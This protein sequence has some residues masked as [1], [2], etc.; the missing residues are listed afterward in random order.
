MF[1][2]AKDNFQTTKQTTF[3]KNAYFFFKNE[4]LRLDNVTKE[5]RGLYKC[6]ADNQVRPPDT[7]LVAVNVFFK[8]ETKPVQDTVGQAQNR[9]FDAKLECRVSG[10]ASL[11]WLFLKKTSRS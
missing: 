7:Y 6:V 4:I 10:N 3:F 2:V 9:Q 8:P 1:K 5:D 11:A